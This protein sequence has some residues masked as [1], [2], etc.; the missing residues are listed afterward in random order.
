MFHIDWEAA[1]RDVCKTGSTTIHRARLNLVGFHE[2]GKTSVARS[3]LEKPFMENV[4]STDGIQTELIH[5]TYQAESEAL[6]QWR[7]VTLDTEEIVKDF[8]EMVV[9]TRKN[10]P[11]PDTMSGINPEIRATPSDILEQNRMST[12][13]PGN[14]EKDSTTLLDNVIT[15]PIPEQHPATSA[16]EPSDSND[17]KLDGKTLND[18]Q[19]LAETSKED[20]I[21]DVVNC[22]LRLWDFGGQVEFLATHHFFLD[23]EAIYLIVMDITK[24]FRNKFH[25]SEA[26]LHLPNSPAQFLDYCI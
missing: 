11:K 5:K 24:G 3:L 20:Q 17:A 10:L 13:Q 4:G 23:S 18:I 2:A 14:P 9:K 19:I 8:N 16:N 7:E 22:S 12:L 25:D 21:E 26:Y 6:G 15:E 1:Y